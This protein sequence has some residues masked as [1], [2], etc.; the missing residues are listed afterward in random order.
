M[1]HSLLGALCEISHTAAANSALLIACG[2][3]K[4]VP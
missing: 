4:V 3:T 1:Q 2:Q